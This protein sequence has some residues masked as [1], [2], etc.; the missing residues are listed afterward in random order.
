MHTPETDST[1]ALVRMLNRLWR[2]RPELDK[3]LL[4][5]GVVLSRLCERGNF[6]PQLFESVADSAE[7]IDAEKHR[8]LDT[9]LDKL[10]ARY[11]RQVVYFGSV[12][13]SREAAPMRIS[14]THIPDLAKESD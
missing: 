6:T 9:T 1:V 14:F 4:H 5:V 11:G 12:Q 13:E 7:S 3:P 8:R 2:D 10:R